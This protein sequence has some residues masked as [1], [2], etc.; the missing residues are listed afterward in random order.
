MHDT[1]G[2][3]IPFILTAWDDERLEQ[4]MNYWADLSKGEWSEEEQRSRYDECD[5]ACRR[6]LP[7]FPQADLLVRA[8]LSDPK[9]GYVPPYIIFHSVLPKGKSCVLFTKPSHFPPTYLTQDLPA[10][11]N[12]PN[13][14]EIEC[15]PIDM[16]I[17]RSLV[18]NS[19]LVRKWDTAGPKR[20]LCNLWGCEVQHSQDSDKLMRCQRCKEVLYCSVAHQRLDWNVHK[21]VCEKKL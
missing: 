13:C 6:I 5:A 14:T 9:V 20:V 19:S 10:S 15:A 18:D 8:L 16:S 4:A 21:N 12:S 3:D 7:C 17:S 1:G 11:C 2:A